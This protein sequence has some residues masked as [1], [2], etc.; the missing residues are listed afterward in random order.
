[1]I[2]FRYTKPF[3]R[4]DWIVESN[5]QE[6]R[7]IIDFYKG[8]TSEA[9]KEARSKGGAGAPLPVI[10]M[11]MDVRPAVDSPTAAFLRLRVFFMRLFGINPFSDSVAKVSGKESASSAQNPSGGKT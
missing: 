9:A 3:D 7:Y 11:H 1:M 8:S 4:H 6:I 2:S 10:A 5:G